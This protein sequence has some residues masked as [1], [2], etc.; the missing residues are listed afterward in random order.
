[1]DD[2]Q[3]PFERLAVR[4]RLQAQGRI[5][6]FWKKN[7]QWAKEKKVSKKRQNAL[8]DTFH[9]MQEVVKIERE[10][11]AEFPPDGGMEEVQ[12]IADKD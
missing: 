6:P 9:K 12:G 5:M 3:K 8:M 7:Y 4:A 2:F 1:M 10:R 11:A